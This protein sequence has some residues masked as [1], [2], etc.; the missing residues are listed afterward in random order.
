MAEAAYDSRG[1]TSRGVK[2]QAYKEP[3]MSEP[4]TYL[5]TEAHRADLQVALLAPDATNG[6]AD[7]DTGPKSGT[8][9]G[10]ISG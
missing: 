4:I 3:G 7:A 8:R 6:A 1:G 10:A 9:P 2:P 5:G